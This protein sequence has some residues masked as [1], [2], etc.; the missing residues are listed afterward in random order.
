MKNITFL[1]CFFCNPLQVALGTVIICLT[2]LFVAL[3]NSLQ[4]EKKEKKTC[5]TADS[6]FLVIVRQKVAAC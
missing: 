3:F 2:C 4:R 5:V 6:K 1:L